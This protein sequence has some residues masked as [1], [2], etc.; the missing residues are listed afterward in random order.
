MRD[1]RIFCKG[2]DK[3]AVVNAIKLRVTTIENRVNNMDGSKISQEDAVLC[4]MVLLKS[5]RG[6]GEVCLVTGI[7]TLTDK[8]H[9]MG[10]PESLH[11]AAILQPIYDKIIKGGADKTSTLQGVDDLLAAQEERYQGG[12]DQQMSC[13][14]A[15]LLRTEV[16]N[17]EE[18]EA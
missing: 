2:V 3:L 12:I 10:D 9:Q 16:K 8:Y 6:T 11:L 18:N 14:H 4:L 17:E 5:W 15:R 7:I 1:W 13:L